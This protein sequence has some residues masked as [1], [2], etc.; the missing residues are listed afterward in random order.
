MFC[1]LHIAL[2]VIGRARYII[3]FARPHALTALHPHA[4][5]LTPSQPCTLMPHALTP[6]SPPREHIPTHPTGQGQG[7]GTQRGGQ[8]RVT[9]DIFGIE[10][11]AKTH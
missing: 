10:L 4:S 9:K 2:Y 6:H 3:H 8:S 5:H 1:Y 7:G 11:E